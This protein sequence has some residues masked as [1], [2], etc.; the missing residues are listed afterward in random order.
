MIL[1]LFQSEMHTELPA[2][3]EKNIF[4]SQGKVREFCEKFGKFLFK[5][6][7]E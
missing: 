6:K 4:Q 1:Y 3:R 5:E 7:S 2:V